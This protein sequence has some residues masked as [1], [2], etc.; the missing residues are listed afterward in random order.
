MSRK[1]SV[2]VT[3][4]TGLIGRSIITALLKQGR[5]VVVTSRGH[6]MD[7]E[8][9]YDADQSRL[10]HVE[11]DLLQEH[12]PAQLLDA[13]DRENV[14]IGQFVHAARSLTSLAVNSDGYTDP[15]NFRAE[16]EL[17]VVLPY[18]VVLALRQQDRHPLDSVVLLGSQYGL[19]APNPALYGGD[20]TRSPIQ[21]GVSKAALHHLARELAARLAPNTRVNAIAFGGFEGRADD[22]FDN[23][24]GSM[25]PAG[26]MLRANEA[27]GPVLF[28]LSDSSASVTGAVLVADGGWSIW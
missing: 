7:E 28:L 8:S 12:A 11:I 21:Y 2:L 5:T 14:S 18:R 20:L 4:G 26:R 3:G 10:I 17:Q 19:V 1:N 25:A 23:R 27:V 15:E 13:L 9:R 6:A 22:V 24:Y 16:F